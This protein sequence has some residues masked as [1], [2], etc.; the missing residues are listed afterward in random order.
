MRASDLRSL[1]EGEAWPT[2]CPHVRGTAS[3]HS[4][5]HSR[6]KKHTHTIQVPKE[7]ADFY[8]YLHALQ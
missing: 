5:V 8:K 2:G 4:C 1:S 7:N 6:Q 3:S